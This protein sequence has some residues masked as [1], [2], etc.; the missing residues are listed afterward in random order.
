MV[1]DESPD[2][3]ST[4]TL[5]QVAAFAAFDDAGVRWAVMRDDPVAPETADIDLLVHPADAPSLDAILAP[6]GF[7]RLTAWRHGDHRFSVAYDDTH[8]TWIKL[9]V[10]TRLTYRAGRELSARTIDDVLAR[11]VR[12]EGAWRLHPHDEFWALLLHCLLDRGTV[13]V[14]HSE[15]LREL[16]VTGPMGPLRD[17][18][19]SPQLARDLVAA[20]AKAD[21]G[22]LVALSGAVGAGLDRPPRLA[23]ALRRARS[24]AS[25]LVKAVRRTGLTVAVLGPDGSG[26]STLVAGLSKGFPVPVRTQYLG[27]YG[28]G[29]RDVRGARIPGVTLATQLFTSWKAYASAAYHRRRGRLV[30]FD[31]YGYDALL[32]SRRGV[33]SR[34]HN[35]RRAMIG[36]LAPHPDLVLILDAPAESVHARKAEYGVDEIERRRI[37]YRRLG[38]RLARRTATELI[39]ASEDAAVVRRKATSLVWREVVRRGP[40]GHA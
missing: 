19:S 29:R 17:A 30:V 27:L 35:V 3:L 9:D 4:A 11:R 31:R 13:P 1:A 24:A 8:D 7:A 2:L 36:Q 5:P 33:P 37:G 10:V 22:A 32:P 26:K 38:A 23:R 25:P 28:R 14:R 15:R 40:G 21:P 39:D 6:L 34:K 20:A 16:A 18:L 12:V